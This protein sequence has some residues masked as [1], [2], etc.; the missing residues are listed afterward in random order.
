MTETDPMQS[1]ADDLAEKIKVRAEEIFDADMV[2]T[3]KAVAWADVPERVRAIY[4]MAARESIMEELYAKAPSREDAAGA[5]SVKVEIQK[6]TTDMWVFADSAGDELL[7][8]FRD[9]NGTVDVQ[10]NPS[11]TYSQAAQAF[12]QIVFEQNNRVQNIDFGRALSYMRQGFRVARAED[13]CVYAL[14]DDALTCTIDGV[15]YPCDEMQVAHLLAQDW[16]V[17][18]KADA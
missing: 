3:G 13:N 15:S 10:I 9:A 4:Y 11:L 18:G 8:L 7:R 1:M 17:H 5:E 12:S 14:A 16:Y 6:N 2:Q